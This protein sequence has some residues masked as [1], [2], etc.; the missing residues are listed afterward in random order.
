M[1][2][3]V[4]TPE[5][6]ELADALYP[7]A[8][9]AQ[10]K[11]AYWIST[12]R[13]EY[14]THHGNNEWCRDCGTFMVRHLRRRE[15]DRGKRRDY[16]LDGGWSSEHDTLISCTQCG[17]R[18]ACSLLSYG[19][20]E[21]IGYFE[22]NGVRPGNAADAYDLSEALFALEYA[23]MEDRSDLRR[24]CKVGRAAIKANKEAGFL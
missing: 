17:A 21:E 10:V 11:A 13:G 2:D 20:W 12:P 24:A 15:R 9:Q 4:H 3:I 8:K 6:R 18:L 5:L 22:E 1:P 14:Q 23:T 7:L 16:I 19:A